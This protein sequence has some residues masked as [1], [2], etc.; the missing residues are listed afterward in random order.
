MKTFIRITYYLK[1]FITTCLLICFFYNIIINLFYKNELPFLEMGV[2]IVLLTSLIK[3]N[4]ISLFLLITYPLFFLLTFYLSN[5]D[6]WITGKIYFALRFNILLDLIID[7][8][9]INNNMI[10]YY[11]FWFCK[12]IYFYVFLY[13][14]FFEL[15]LRIMKK[16]NNIDS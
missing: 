15:P 13:I 10:L 9:I 6:Y 16:R 4:K 1:I 12:G 5:L 7:R 2:I 11:L 8:K 3:R 14:I